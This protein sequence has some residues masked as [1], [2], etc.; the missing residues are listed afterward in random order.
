MSNEETKPA[1]EGFAIV[2][3][4]GRNTIAGYVTEISAFGTAFLRVDVPEVNG[5]PAYTKLFGGAAIYA[6]TPTSEEIAKEAAGRLD[7]RPVQNWIVPERKEL[8]Q[9]PGDIEIY[10]D[11]DDDWH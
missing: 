11:D 8:P 4:F 10:D 1:F 6:V 7:V 5:Q 2:E 9:L 3:L